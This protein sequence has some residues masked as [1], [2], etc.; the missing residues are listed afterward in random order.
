M[1]QSRTRNKHHGYHPHRAHQNQS[2]ATSHRP[3]TP[4]KSN[5]ELFF[6]SFIG[7]M[8]AVIGFFMFDNHWV[9]V[10]GGTIIG[11]GIGYFIGRIIAKARV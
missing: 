2:S 11:A 9:A 7:F 3:I 10:L 5:T 6:S 1:P 4:S 8:G